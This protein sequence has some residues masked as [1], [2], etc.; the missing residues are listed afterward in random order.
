MEKI[1]KRR[2]SFRHLVQSDRDRIE[3][4]KDEGHL[5]KEIAKI[6]KVDASSIS[7]EIKGRKKKNGNYEATNAQRK[8]NCKRS[9]SKYQG[10]KIEANQELKEHIIKG[11]EASQSPDE[12]AGK[13]K[14][15]KLAFSVGTN[16]IYKWLYSS[17]GQQYCKC[18]CTKRY[19]KKKQKGLPKRIMIKDRI[20][21]SERPKEGVHAE[22]DLF[23]SPTKTGTKKSGAIICVPE[24]KL[25]LARF[26]KNKKPAV[27]TQATN[28]LLEEVSIDDLT[29]DNG[30]ENRG[31][32]QFTVPVFFADPHAPWQKPNVE[33]SIGLLRRWFLPKGTDLKKVT[34]QEL[35]GYLHILNGKY[36]KSLGYRS[37]YEVSLE[38][39]IIQKVPTLG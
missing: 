31:H 2:K 17:W 22:G 6:L 30:I 15:D 9:N 7:R 4:L 23:V 35:Q 11:L 5:Q 34:E 38:R 25:L 28:K 32:K 16:A 36:R 24:T 29:M 10:M 1:K 26:I 14:K 18:L 20:S 21:L 37:A 39:G 3:A 8:A 12:I 27:M 13:M 33:N 19:K